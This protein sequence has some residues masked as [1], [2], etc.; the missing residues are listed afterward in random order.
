MFRFLKVFLSISFVLILS[1]NSFAFDFCIDCNAPINASTGDVISTSKMDA[2][3]ATGTDYVRLNFILG[4]WNSPTDTTLQGPNNWTWFQTYDYI[5]DGFRSRGL[6][7][8]ALIGAES[9]KSSMGNNLNNQTYCD[10]LTA[11]FVSIVNHFKD[12]VFVYESFNEPN[13]WAGGSSAQL[14]PY[15][16]S[17]LLQKI[18][19]DVKY[20]NGHWSDPS[21][22]VTLISGPLFS[23]DSDNCASYMNDVYN[24]GINSLQWNNCQT[25]TGKYPLDGI[26]YHIYV[27]EGP[28]TIATVQN[29]INGNLNAIWNTI[30]TYEGNGT[31]KK[32]W[33]SE[34]G[35]RTDYVSESEQA[36][37][38]DVAY[39]LYKVD[40]RIAMAS[41]FCIQDFPNGYYGL[42]RS[43][44]FIESNKK[45]SWT[46]YY[47][48]THGS[49]PADD[50][51]FISNDVPTNMQTNEVKTVIITVKN[52][53]SA[54]WQNSGS[55]NMYRLA[56]G[57]TSQG[58]TY[59]ND[60]LWSNFANGGYSISQTDQ[61]AYTSTT[62]NPNSTITYTFDIT[63]PSTSGIYH[64]EARMVHD[65][66]AFFGE[67]LS[68]NVTVSNPSS[69]LLTNPSF[70]TGDLTGW[71]S[72]G[73]V[74]GVQTGTWLAGI[75]AEDGS[76]L[77]GTAANWGQKN[78]GVYQRVSAENGKLYIA[79]IKHKTYRIGGSDGD[80]ASRIGLDPNG[81][82]NP[83]STNIQWS[84]W[85][86]TNTIWDTLN[87]SAICT[88]NYITLFLQHF[89][90]APEWNINCFDNASLVVS[91]S[92][93]GN[94]MIYL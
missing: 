81:G 57:L 22:Q 41:W 71:T 49:P 33:I 13:D 36:R 26:G 15:W 82:T 75:T 85:A 59:N 47:N 62:V 84:S 14:Q 27:A 25:L 12:R 3:T 18:Y 54:T 76:Y 61:R 32:L 1:F 34:F 50:A 79:T 16:F 17:Y 60:F 93:I 45:P 77:L 44:A 91:N 88:S 9:V 55:A 73:Q 4:P 10:E 11:N 74:D 78:G 92:S 20:N 38:V 51:F 42:F 23:H 89:Q 48:Q 35:W 90:S 63:A 83:S 6:K 66:V 56:A 58:N 39:N 80:V 37:N 72:F 2:I 52:T 7:I 53:G 86:Y 24:N 69:N 21:W 31:P 5:I 87:L 40:N 19:M 65:G 29:K 68:R 30:T 94:F 64:F 28:S 8:Y 70:E 67:T 46:N 43:G